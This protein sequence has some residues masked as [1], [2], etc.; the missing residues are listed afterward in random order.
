MIIAVSFGVFIISVIILYVLHARIAVEYPEITVSAGRVLLELTPSSELARRLSQGS[1]RHRL[2]P[3]Y[4]FV[5]Y[6]HLIAGLVFAFS[7][8]IFAY[9]AVR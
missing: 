8:M 7:I 9:T 5:W 4:R 1:V 3:L 6:V 2:A